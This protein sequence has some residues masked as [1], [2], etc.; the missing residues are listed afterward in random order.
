MAG[1]KARICELKGGVVRESEAIPGYGSTDLR[2]EGVGM[3]VR[4]K[5]SPD[6]EVLQREDRLYY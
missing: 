6:Y 1:D 3:C 4:A 5:Q 2:A